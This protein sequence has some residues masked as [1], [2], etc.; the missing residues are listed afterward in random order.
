MHLCPCARV[1]FFYSRSLFLLHA[2]TSTAI[3][4]MVFWLLYQKER[5]HSSVFGK[6]SIHLCTLY[7]K[8]E[9]PYVSFDVF[10]I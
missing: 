9:T 6:F 2:H 1:V 3:E 7:I 4:V 8:L 5:I 10:I